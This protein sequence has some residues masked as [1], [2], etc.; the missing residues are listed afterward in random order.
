MFLCLPCFVILV[1]PGLGLLE[2]IAL[3]GDP[4]FNIFQASV[5]YARKRAIEIMG[6]HSLDGFR[7][8]VTNNSL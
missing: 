1:V 6:A 5:P 7:K 4:S 8:R 2:G 3:S